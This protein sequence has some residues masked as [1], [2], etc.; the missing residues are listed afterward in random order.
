MGVFESVAGKSKKARERDQESL[1]GRLGEILNLYL[2]G[3]DLGWWKS[4]T[5]AIK[6]ALEKKKVKVAIKNLRQP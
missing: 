5:K 4:D 3:V 6:S 2:W 1:K